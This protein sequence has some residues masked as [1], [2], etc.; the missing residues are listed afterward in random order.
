MWPLSM[1]Q[2]QL[3]LA[4]RAIFKAHIPGATDS[5]D[6]MGSRKTLFT[7]QTALDSWQVQQY[8]NFLT[9]VPCTFPKALCMHSLL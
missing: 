5:A 8:Y 4:L 2:P 1:F 7:V 9:S 6:D 3:H